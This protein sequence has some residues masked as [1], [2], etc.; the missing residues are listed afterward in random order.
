MV[1]ARDCADHQFLPAVLDCTVVVFAALTA[2]FGVEDAS[3][4]LTT[5]IRTII[6]VV[7]EAGA[8]P[9]PPSETGNLT[10]GLVISSEAG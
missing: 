3:S 5:F 1:Q 9:S 2:R 7:S 6:M 8:T 4:D 10:S